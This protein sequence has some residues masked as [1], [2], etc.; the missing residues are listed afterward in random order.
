[1]ATPKEHI[2]SSFCSVKLHIQVIPNCMQ[3]VVSLKLTGAVCM[4]VESQY[5]VMV[6]DKEQRDLGSNAHSTMKLSSGT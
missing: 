6:M 2:A 1:M 4:G 3:T 5:G